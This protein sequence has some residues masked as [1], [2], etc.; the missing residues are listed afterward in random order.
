MH[1]PPKRSAPF[2]PAGGHQAGSDPPPAGGIIIDGRRGAP[3]GGEVDPQWQFGLAQAIAIDVATQINETLG[4]DPARTDNPPERVIAA[5]H[6]MA[7]TI[8]SLEAFLK[9]VCPEEIRYSL[10]AFLDQFSSH[11][12]RTVLNPTDQ[13]P[14]A[15]E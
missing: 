11:L 8:A 9:R 12:D 15:K 1:H 3:Q 6:V 7:F 5:I 13:A 10:R 14:A 2:R 4:I